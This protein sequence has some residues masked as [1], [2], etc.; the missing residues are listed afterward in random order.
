MED[1]GLTVLEA[2]N[3]LVGYQ[4]AREEHPDL[5]IMDISM[6]IMDGKK[7][8]SLIRDD[9]EVG[10]TPI[11]VLTA[12]SSQPEEI[13][14]PELRLNGYLS[15]PVQRWQVI[16]ELKRFLKYESTQRETSRE[17]IVARKLTWKRSASFQCIGALN[18]SQ[19]SSVEEVARSPRR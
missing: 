9:P 7:S 4:M 16:A 19:K 10:D 1:T 18:L 11:V 6:P 14:L 13:L 2:E 8:T 17:K 15:K 12:S 3:G 5:I